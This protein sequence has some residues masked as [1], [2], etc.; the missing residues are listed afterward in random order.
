MRKILRLYRNWRYRH[1]Y[2]ELLF[3]YAKNEKTCV[4]AS[5]YADEMFHAITG[6][7]YQVIRGD[8]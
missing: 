8:E 6:L 7:Y 4:Y 2:R 3:I 1:L 5:A